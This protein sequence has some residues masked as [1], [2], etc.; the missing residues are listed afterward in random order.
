MRFRPDLELL[1]LCSIEFGAQHGYLIFHKIKASASGLF[2]FGEGQ[3]YPILHKL[4]S[5]G[6][7]SG[8]WAVQQGRPSRR[9]YQITDSGRAL[10]REKREQWKAFRQAMDSAIEPAREPVA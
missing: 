4:E 7:I 1:I 9:V 10:L 8:E 3:L 5:A 6:H 2:K